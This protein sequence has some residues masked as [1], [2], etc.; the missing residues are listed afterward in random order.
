M[1]KKWMGN[2]IPTGNLLACFHFLK[3]FPERKSGEKDLLFVARI[4][5]DQKPIFF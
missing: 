4:G 3:G 1:G 5:G 2:P